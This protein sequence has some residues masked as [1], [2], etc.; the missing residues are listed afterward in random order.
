MELLLRTFLVANG[1]IKRIGLD[2]FSR[3]GG[4][5]SPEFAGQRIQYAILAFDNDNG[6]LGEL[7]YREFA[8]FTFDKNG[9]LDREND[10]AQH[11]VMRMD[12]IES[13]IHLFACAEYLQTRGN[14]GSRSSPI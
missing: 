2:R 1:Q 10:W 13:L 7:R 8:Y 6:K 5:A 14:N 4:T 9:N 3:I 11:L 12:T